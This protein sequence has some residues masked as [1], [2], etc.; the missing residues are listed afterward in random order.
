MD[1][2]DTTTGVTWQDARSLVWLPICARL[3]SVAVRVVS[4][5][6]KSQCLKV[7]VQKSVLFDGLALPPGTHV[8]A[9]NMP[10]RTGCRSGCI[11]V[12]LNA[13]CQLCEQCRQYRLISVPPLLRCCS[14][15]NSAHRKL[16][17]LLSLVPCCVLLYVGPSWQL[18]Y[19]Q[20]ATK[21]VPD[22]LS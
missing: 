14:V 8:S 12:G 18:L 11:A 20:R 6:L 15:Q 1:V 2:H 3:L 22:C 5:T 21:S 10:C 16:A 4:N 19:R 9:L 17:L 13:C 7:S